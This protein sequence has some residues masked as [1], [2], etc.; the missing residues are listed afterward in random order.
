MKAPSN[1]ENWVQSL[2][3][4]IK[5]SIGTN[6]QIKPFEGKTKLRIRL[7]NGRR[8]ET[9]IGIEWSKSKA[10]DILQTL[11]KIHHLTIKKEVPLEE[12]I[13]QVKKIQT[14]ALRIAATPAPKLLLHA[15]GKYENHKVNI[16]KD[17]TQSSWNQEYGGKSNHG[18]LPPRKKDQGKTYLHLKQVK[19]NNADE[20]LQRIAE[21]YEYGT[22]NRYIRVQHISAF[23]KWATSKQSGFLLPEKEWT[24][25]LK[26]KLKNYIGRELSPEKIQT[27][28]QAI[29]IEDTD[30][31]QLINSLP[32]DVDKDQK[33][34]RLRDR[35]MEWDLAL[36]LSIVYGLR[37]CEVSHEYLEVKKNEKEFLWCSYSKKVGSH[38]T[39]PRR[40][41]PLHPKWEKEWH[42]I[43]RIKNKAP[44]PR[45]KISAADAF[46][47]YL[48]FNEVWKRIKCQHGVLPYS[49][50]HSYSKRAHLIYKMSTS[51]VAAI[52]GHSV[53]EHVST[54]EPWINISTMRIS[55]KQSID[56]VSNKI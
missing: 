3:K 55:N 56:D 48:R 24:P 46:K 7:E 9:V 30:L 5:D 49:F 27:A 42:L 10:E 31:L 33:K 26:N 6:W 21:K 54:Y 34:H 25:P 12:A 2:R 44:L 15:W 43:K 51:Q 17:I 38:K 18:I 32:I 11:E 39:K 37:P 14:K 53:K 16:T 23:L 13:V 8:I 28:A 4:K 20:L 40:L 41:S 1:S 47:N 22:K 29:A 45:M 50:R 35:A 19:A 52:M 36:K